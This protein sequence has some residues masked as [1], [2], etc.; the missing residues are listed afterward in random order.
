M[1]VCLRWAVPSISSSWLSSSSS[2]CG[3]ASA[4]R[5]PRLDLQ[6]A[7]AEGEPT[8]HAVALKAQRIA[9][10]APGKLE[11]LLE[12][13]RHRLGQP[14]GCFRSQVVRAP[15]VDLAHRSSVS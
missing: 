6:L 15:D 2:I 8:L 5:Q 9:L 4:S 3:R 13:Y 1:V 11:A 7:G 14:A 12:P 10:P